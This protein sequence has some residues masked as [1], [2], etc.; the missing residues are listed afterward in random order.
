MGDLCPEC[1]N[2]KHVN[3]TR[4]AL[5]DADEIVPCRCDCQTPRDLRAGVAALESRWLHTADTFTTLDGD[6]HALNNPQ[7]ADEASRMAALC[8]SHAA[9]LRDLLETTP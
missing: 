5:S 8:R 4:E 2:G 6:W 7:A 9:E 1:R 3:C